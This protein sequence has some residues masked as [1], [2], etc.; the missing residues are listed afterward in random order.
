MKKFVFY[1][2][3]ATLLLCAFLLSGCLPGKLKGFWAYEIQFAEEKFNG[4]MEI[5][6][7]LGSY[8]VRM[9]SFQEGTIET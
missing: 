5:A 4:T 9:I 6:P 3:F 7:S 8:A 2:F 1:I